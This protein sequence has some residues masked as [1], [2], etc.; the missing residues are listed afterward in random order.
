[1]QAS[2]RM[3]LTNHSH[4]RTIRLFESMKS[5]LSPLM[6]AHREAAGTALLSDTQFDDPVAAAE[7]AAFC[8]AC[9][10]F[11]FGLYLY[12]DAETP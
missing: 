8:K 4:T 3:E 11:G 6:Q 2:H 9:A 5:E 10:R 12:H 7:E 1:M